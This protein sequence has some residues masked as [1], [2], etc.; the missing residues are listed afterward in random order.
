MRTAEGLA[1]AAEASKPTTTTRQSFAGVIGANL[2][3]LRL[4]ADWT[5][6]ALAEAMKALGFR[7][8]RIT[9]AEV[10]IATRRVTMEEVFAL[11]VLFAVP[12]VEMFAP[13]EGTVVEWRH[14]DL[15]GADVVE[16]FVGEGGA[17]GEGGTS[18]RTAARAAG[19]PRTRSDR[20][21]A[22]DLWANR[23]ERL[24]QPA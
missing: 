19:K 13:P 11:S 15:A 1:R 3:A 8:Q 9:C 2:K 22:V 5:Q 7:W 21:P 16:L 20:R 17:P 24:N 12:V 23:T 10:E 4:E 18:W 14:G 6:L